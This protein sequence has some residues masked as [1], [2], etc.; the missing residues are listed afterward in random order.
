MT[1]R[2]KR[3][4][5]IIVGNTVGAALTVL[6]IALSTKNT[7]FL[8]NI[9]PQEVSTAISGMLGTMGIIISIFINLVVSAT[10]LA[11]SI[12]T[13][14]YFFLA[15]IGP[16]IA[17]IVG[18]AVVGKD[19]F[20]VKDVL[21]IGLML[22]LVFYLWMLLVGLGK[23]IWFAIF[24]VLHENSDKNKSKKPKQEQ[25][26]EEYHEDDEEEYYDDEESQE[27]EEGYEDDYD[28][29]FITN[30]E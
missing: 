25:L 24:G 26:T 12:H 5:S 22:L 7:G 1:I 28:T 15:P 3:E 13:P 6:F 2:K 8:D 17:Y 20:E 19:M 27:E 29:F 10:T 14:K 30:E 23:V 21:L 11:Y 18:I 16:S 4:L 9:L